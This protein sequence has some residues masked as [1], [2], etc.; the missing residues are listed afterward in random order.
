MVSQVEDGVLGIL[1]VGRKYFIKRVV[2]FIVTL[3]DVLNL[4]VDLVYL[5]LNIINLRV[6]FE[7]YFLILFILLILHHDYAVTQLAIRL[8]DHLHLSFVQF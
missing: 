2:T 5:C 3:L 6:H 4:C 7:Y 8:S 1:S